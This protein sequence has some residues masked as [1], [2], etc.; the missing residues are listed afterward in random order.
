MLLA[1][2][3]LSTVLLL[4]A[5]VSYNV[6]LTSPNPRPDESIRVNS[7][8]G[9]VFPMHLARVVNKI[10]NHFMVGHMLSEICALWATI[11]FDRNMCP[12]IGDSFVA[13]AIYPS[14]HIPLHAIP[15][16]CFMVVFGGFVREICHRQL[17]GMFTWETSVLKDHKLI[18]SGPYRFVRH[19]AYTGMICLSIGYLWLLNVPET[20]VKECFIGTAFLPATID[21]RSALGAL[22]RTVYFTFYADVCVFGVRRS[23]AEDRLLKQKFGKEWDDWAKKV[24][25]NVLPYVL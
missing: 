17:G 24:R 10:I 1:D 23:F 20:F 13:H 25:W 6:G 22:Y 16:L 5:T 18:T 7:G 2:T 21:V 14:H 11:R 3:I 19:P 9:R 4:A 12:S 8:I 15:P